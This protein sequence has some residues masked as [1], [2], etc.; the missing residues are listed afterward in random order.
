MT[1]IRRLLL[2]LTGL[3]ASGAALTS[4]HDV[5][6]YDNNFEGN[7]DALW[8]ILDE[9]YCFFRE[10][11]IDWDSVRS[12]YRPRVEQ[13]RTSRQLFELC[14]AMLDELRDGHTNLSAPF[15]TSY[16]RKWWSD[17]PAGYNERLVQE[18]YFNFNYSQ[19]G[20]VTYGMLQSGMAYIHYPSFS[21]ALGD[22]NIDYILTS[23][24]SAPGLIIDVRDNGG[25]AISNVEMWV[26]RFIR[27]RTLAGFISHK[28]GPG[29]D[30]FSKPYAYYFDPAESGRAMWFKPIVVL[31]D[32]STFSAANNF[33]SVM[34]LLPQVTVIGATTG[35]GSGMPFSSEIPCGWGVR[36]SAC[37]VTDAEGRPT[38][39]GIDPSPGCAVAFDPEAALRGSD[40]V[41]DFAINYLITHP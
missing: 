8:T 23:F 16:Y 26:R 14:S 4:C 18:Y 33:V 30:D 10:K 12:V 2:S 9:H 39:F 21:D 29:H 5:P 3:A 7:F 38:E 1:L 20:S 19:L 41:L 36:F 31:T 28:T 17:Y 35:G 13:C 15:A 37:P 32:R 22:G 6:D 24:I 34:R 27:E 11:G 40:T 25:G